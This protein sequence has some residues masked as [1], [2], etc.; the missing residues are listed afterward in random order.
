M[1]LEEAGAG[2]GYGHPSVCE[3]PADLVPPPGGR[4]LVHFRRGGG[5]GGAGLSKSLTKK[6]N[7]AIIAGLSALPM[8]LIEISTIPLEG[9]VVDEALD[10]ASVHVAG[11]ETFALRPGGR[12]SLPVGAGRRRE[13]PRERPAPG[14]ARSRVQ[15]LSCPLRAAREPGPRSLLP[16]APGRGGRE[17]RKRTR[18][19]STT[20]TWSWP[21]TTGRAWTSAR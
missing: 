5:A 14:R 13:R 15:P 4:G 19:S 8:L 2:H 10:P 12:L 21:T 18:S 9:R 11:E 7:S 16:P 3:A 20:T 17:R 1:T 6:R